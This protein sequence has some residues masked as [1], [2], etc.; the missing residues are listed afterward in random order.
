MGTTRAEKGKPSGL[1]RFFLRAP[2]WLYKARMGWLLG[3][4]FLML[5]HTGRKSGL[6]RHV[7]VEVVNHD[8]DTD[9]YY[10]ASGW[11]DEADWY[12]NLLKTKRVEVRV[13]TR[14]FET[15]AALLSKEEG[16]RVLTGYAERNPFAF[17]NLSKFM[18]G[19]Q[20]PPGAEGAKRLAEHVPLVALPAPPAG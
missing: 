4:R 16:T 13:G 3:G 17:K 18:L 6:P 20:A 7:V 5:T 2:I 15:D 10:V 8:E 11:G 14:R 12:Q 1:M 9:T 19:E